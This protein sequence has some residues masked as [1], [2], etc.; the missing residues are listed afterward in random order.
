MLFCFSVC[1]FLLEYLLF[2]PFNLCFISPFLLSTSL[3]LSCL[4][5]MLIFSFYVHSFFLFVYLCFCYGLCLSFCSYSVVLSVNCSL[6]CFISFF[7]W[8]LYSIFVL[9]FLLRIVF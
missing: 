1:F 3:F 6:S 9:R 5:L 2:L 7:R 4:P 8:P